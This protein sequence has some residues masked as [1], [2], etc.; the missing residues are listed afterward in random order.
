[1][2]PGNGRGGSGAWI[3]GLLLVLTLV[4]VVALPFFL[5]PKRSVTARADDTVIVVTPHN[6]AVR[7]EFGR[8]FAEWYRTRTGRTITVDWRVVGGTSDIVRLI[9][10]SYTAAFERHWKS[11]GREWSAEI[12]AAFAAPKLADDASAEARVARAEYLASE[13]S[14]GMDVFFGGGSYDYVRQAAAGNIVPA[15][16]RRVHPEWFTEDAIPR[17]FTGEE[18]WDGEDRWFGNVIS[19]YGILYNR[20]A[21]ARLGLP[22]PQVWADLADPRYRGELAL[23]DPTKSSSMSKAFENMIQQQM[24][25]RLAAL[26]PGRSA[27]AAAEGWAGGMRL[28][29]AMAANARYFT[30]SSQKP[31]IDVAQGDC[32]AGICIDYYGRSQAEAVA[33]RGRAR[34]EFVTPR[35]GSEDSVDPIAILRGAPNR[36]AAELFL[37]YTLTPDAQKLWNFK[38]GTPGGPERFALRR[39][40]VRKDFYARADWKAWRSDPEA[41]PYED[42]TPLTYRP[43][44]TAHLFRETAFIVRVMCMDNH[45]ELVAA[46]RAAQAA[47]EPAR[48][49]ALSVLHDV[50]AVDYGQANGA[51]KR[52]L[53]AKD[54][55]GELRLAAELG[56]RFREQYARAG[57]LAR[58]EE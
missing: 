51:I 47:P 43:E 56:R 15:R 20:D 33:Q 11:Q 48:S 5:R 39:L 54:K 21:L 22:A 7:H 30:D 1:M 41:A 25:D 35:G 2:K 13:A 28:L 38:P 40:P 49:R 17:R 8:G 52:T 12:Q 32:A 18:Y 6:E 44:W 4:A 27:Q 55:V 37:E 26:G 50:G 14:C 31:P 58:G 29:Q 45:A 24:S 10:A 3:P 53:T 34:L 19:S 9:E 16:V 36:E 23:A 42:P 46:W 57:R